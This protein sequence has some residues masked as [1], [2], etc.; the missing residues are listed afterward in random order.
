MQTGGFKGR[1]REVSMEELREGVTFAFQLGPR[2]VVGEYGMD[3]AHQP[4][5][6]RRRARKRAGGAASGRGSGPLFRAALAARHAG[7]SAQ[8]AAGG[9][10]RHRVGALHRPR[11]RRQRRERRDSR[12]GCGAWAEAFSCSGANPVP[13]RA[14][15]HV[16]IEALLQCLKARGGHAS[17][18]SLRRRACW[19]I[20]KP[21]AGRALR[22]RLL[23]TTGLSAPNIELGIARSLE[24]LSRRAKT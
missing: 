6:R 11:Q 12:L 5:V 21:K 14:A 17:S 19:R 7:R 8:P 9:R 15:V 3:R 4:A 20:R 1:T 23:E 18:D 13:R 2:R 22:L 24:T 10:G 16:A